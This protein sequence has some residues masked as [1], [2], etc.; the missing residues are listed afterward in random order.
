MSKTNSDISENLIRLLYRLKEISSRDFSILS[1]VQ[2][3]WKPLPDKWSIA[4]CFRHIL[5]I[6]ENYLPLASTVVE[7]SE[8]DFS[9]NSVFKSGLLGK[10]LINTVKIREDN[11]IKKIMKCPARLS[12]MQ[13]RDI[14]GEVLL[15][16]FKEQTDSAIVL[17]EKS[18]NINL[19]SAK[20]GLP[21]FPYFRLRL[22]DFMS[23]FVYHVERHIVQ[24]Q[25]VYMEDNFPRHSSF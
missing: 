10:Y 16:R 23:Y 18:K 4:E 13:N 21:F 12:P 1:D 2:F 5:L 25:K 7:K 14:N 11:S 6:Y 15:N 17:L 19:A 24:A 22:G 3:N 9:V 20:A 8:P